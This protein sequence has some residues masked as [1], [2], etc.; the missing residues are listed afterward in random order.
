MHCS[1]NV[2]GTGTFNPP[3]LQVQ[4]GCEMMKVSLC[5]ERETFI[6]LCPQEQLRNLYTTIRFLQNLV[7]TN[8]VM[9]FLNYAVVH[10]VL[11]DYDSY[12]QPPHFKY[13]LLNI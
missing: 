4:L 3:P 11:L 1:W 13:N 8:M 7:D 12:I 10:V 6:I 2:T 5:Q 9:L